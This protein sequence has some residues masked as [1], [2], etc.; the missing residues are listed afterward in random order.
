M[1]VTSFLIICFLIHLLFAGCSSSQNTTG[2]DNL[3]VLN[4]TYKHWS[5]PPSGGSD[6]PERGTDLEV[7]LQSWPEGYT[8]EYFVFNSRKSLPVTKHESDTTWIITGRIIRSSAM[9]DEQSESVDLSDRLVYINPKGE[10]EFV[11]IDFVNA[12][13]E[14]Q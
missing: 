13:A 2:N 1:K 8:A 10:A 14:S 5:H 4:A 6:V 3:Q 11:E 7:T 9:L 12:D